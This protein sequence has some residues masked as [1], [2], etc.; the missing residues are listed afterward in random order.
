MTPCARSACGNTTDVVHWHRQTG[1]RYCGRCA[2]KINDTNQ[3]LVVKEESMVNL[4]INRCPNGCDG[5]PTSYIHRAQIVCNECGIAGPVRT[6]FDQAAALWNRLTLAP[7][8]CAC[9]TPDGPVT[10][11]ATALDI[12]TAGE[13][14]AALIPNGWS[15]T[16]AGRKE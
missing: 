11:S 10:I 1:E 15:M 9:P 6:T 5:F 8:S 13:T 4:K 3:G 2:R 14:L 16:V 7:E 12:A